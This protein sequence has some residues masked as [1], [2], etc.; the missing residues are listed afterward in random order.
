MGAIESCWSPR[1]LARLVARRL[2]DVVLV[3]SDVHRGL[4]AATLPATGGTSPG[5]SWLPE[6]D[7]PAVVPVNRLAQRRKVLGGVLNEYHWGA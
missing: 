2:T 5:V 3:T 6:L 1:G 4:V 7:E